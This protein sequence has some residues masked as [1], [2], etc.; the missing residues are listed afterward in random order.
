MFWNNTQ[1]QDF[2]EAKQWKNADEET[3]KVMREITNRVT[4]GWLREEDFARFPC[5]DLKIIND[6]WTRYSKGRFGFS[7]QSRIWES[8]EDNYLRFGDLVGWRVHY[9]WQAYSELQFSLNDASVGHLP[10][11]PFYKS[12]GAAIG[13]A[14]TL[15]PKLED[16]YADD[17]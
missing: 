2:L 1:L 7:V 12:D 10:A 14:A 17:F 4:A 6:L 11:A 9:R 3:G 13:W 5:L 8:V 15:T 16:C